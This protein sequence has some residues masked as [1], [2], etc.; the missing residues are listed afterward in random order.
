MVEE[1]FFHLFN[2]AIV[3]A[4]ILHT[5]TNKKKLSLEIFYKKVAEGCSLVPAQNLKYKVR[6]AVQ[7]AD[8]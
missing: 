2:L 4:H 7:Q 5:K 6:P 8:S 1:T 3:N